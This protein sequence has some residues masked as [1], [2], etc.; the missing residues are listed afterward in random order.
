M[1]HCS[2]AR[3]C[4]GSWFFQPAPQQHRCLS[5]QQTLDPGQLFLTEVSHH[6]AEQLINAGIRNTRPRRIATVAGDKSS[7]P[8]LDTCH[9]LIDFRVRFHGPTSS[10]NS[11]PRQ[12]ET[13]G[14]IVGYDKISIK[15]LHYQQR[16]RECTSAA[17]A[18]HRHFAL[19]ARSVFGRWQRFPGHGSVAWFFTYL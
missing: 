18:K 13:V 8:S 2:R 17:T 4:R 10:Q 16:Y 12:V 3:Q 11:W 14:A 1:P 5:Q 6:D 19:Q 15:S 7:R 9:R